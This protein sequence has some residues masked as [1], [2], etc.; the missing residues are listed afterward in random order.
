[1][2]V[3]G[4]PKLGKMEAMRFRGEVCRKNDSQEI[5]GTGKCRKLEWGFT[6]AASSREGAT[7]DNWLDTDE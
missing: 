4:P 6:L 2:L 5:E 1:M 3:E 7:K